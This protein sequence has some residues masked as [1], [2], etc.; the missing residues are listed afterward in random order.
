MKTKREVRYF[1]ANETPK[2][3]LDRYPT[4]SDPTFLLSPPERYFAQCTDIRPP[5]ASKPPT[6]LF[7]AP[8]CIVTEA[9]LPPSSFP[10]A[11]AQTGAGIASQEA[12][13]AATTGAQVGAVGPSCYRRGSP[14]VAG[15]RQARRVTV[16]AVRASPPMSEGEVGDKGQS[17][18][19][20]PPGN[21]SMPGLKS[22]C[23]SHRRCVFRLNG[24]LARKL[25]KVVCWRRCVFVPCQ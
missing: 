10:G 12:P 18:R 5:T 7:L 11:S 23:G 20:K 22:L 8:G 4:L 19:A 14:S 2:L 6:P 13:Q 17:R 15:R 25:D 9:F 3:P 21:N 24:L 16:A 1:Y